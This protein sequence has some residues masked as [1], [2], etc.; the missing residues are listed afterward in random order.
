MH[1]DGAHTHGGGG[2]AGGA[3][4]VAVGLFFV[5]AAIVYALGPVV[6]AAISLVTVLVIAAISLV[7]LAVIAGA[8][9]WVIRT[10]RR[11]GLEFQAMQVEPARAV[12]AEVI[13]PAS[14]RAAVGVPGRAAIE[15]AAPPSAQHTNIYLSDLSP[16]AAEALGRALNG[17]RP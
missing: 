7:G 8:V 13:P 5:A 17:G 9:V 15:Q 2:S 12:Y 6:S 16:E 10:H 11:Q 1:L 14:P 4:F 3:P